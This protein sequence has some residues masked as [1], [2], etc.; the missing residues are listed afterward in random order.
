MGEMG[1]FFLEICGGAGV[2]LFGNMRGGWGLFILEIWGEMGG[3]GGFWG[4]E[5]G[6]GP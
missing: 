3:G 5:N 1:S 6:F 4:G 2:F